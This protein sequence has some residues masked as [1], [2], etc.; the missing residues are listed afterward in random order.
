MNH[1]IHSVILPYLTLP[2]GPTT[3]S[4]AVQRSDHQV[5]PLHIPAKLKVKKASQ[6][7]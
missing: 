5:G 7:L 1:G 4:G 6:K 3:P 2:S